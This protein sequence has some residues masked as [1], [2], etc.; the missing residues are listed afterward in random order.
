[1]WLGTQSA[2]VLGLLTVTA[3]PGLDAAGQIEGR[4]WL[5]AG[6]EREPMPKALVTLLG[7]N[8]RDRLGAAKTDEEGRFRVVGPF[9]GRLRL[10]VEKP[11][12]VGWND[13]HDIAI[14]CGSISCGPFELELTLGA[15]L[16]GSVFD[17]L[18]QPLEGVRVLLEKRGGPVEGSGPRNSTR[19]R[20]R[21]P[22]SDDQGRFRAYGLEPGLYR[23]SAIAPNRGPTDDLVAADPIDVELEAGRSL[24]ISLALRSRAFGKHKISGRVEADGAVKGARIFLRG[25]RVDPMLRRFSTRA[26]S[27]SAGGGFEIQGIPTGVY[28]VLLSAGPR[29]RS[30]TGRGVSLGLLDIRSDLSGL[31]LSPV[32]PS[33]LRGSIEIDS[34]DPPSRVALFLEPL[35]VGVRQSIRAALP[36]FRFESNQMLPGRYRLRGSP[37]EGFVTGVRAEGGPLPGREVTIG[38]GEIKEIAIVFSNRFGSIGGVVRTRAGSEV[39]PVSHAFV[40]LESAGEAPDQRTIRA[41][42]NGEFLFNQVRP[43][44]WSIAARA[45]EAEVFSEPRSFPLEADADIEVDLTIP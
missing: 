18:G 30:R 26:N 27:L 16:G 4:V 34:D 41:D 33:G 36:D 35:D 5:R 29:N 44:E 32:P 15:V 40:R 1:M 17:D 20:R 3:A 9:E 37:R 38:P 8:S 31:T 12:Y 6:S 14:S 2:L 42:Q 7:S 43:D 19:S 13:L 25:V 45:P 39:H 22:L 24:D 21:G 23:V 28:S 11:G 10:R